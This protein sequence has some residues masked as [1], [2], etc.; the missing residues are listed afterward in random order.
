MDLC[1]PCD[2]TGTFDQVLIGN[3]KR[4]F[5][6]FDEKIIS[7]YARGMSMREVTGA[8]AGALQYRGLGRLDSTVTRAVIE[9]VTTWQSRSLEAIYPLVFL[10]AIRVKIR[11]EALVSNKT[12]HV[13]ISM[14]AG[15]T[16]EVHGLGNEQN[17]GAKF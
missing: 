3:C 7:M 12:I 16:K 1:I 2:R 13:T 17:E 10:D 8:P 14:R 4:R 9:G 5:P 15:G 6:A 11:G